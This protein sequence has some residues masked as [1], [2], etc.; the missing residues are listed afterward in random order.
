MSMAVPSALYRNA[1]SGCKHD[2]R[3]ACIGHRSI[4]NVVNEALRRAILR[5]HEDD[6]FGIAAR[7]VDGEKNN[8]RFED[9]RQRVYSATLEGE[10][11]AGSKFAGVR[12][13]AHPERAFAGEHVQVLVGVA[14]EMWRNFAI[15]AKDP[16]ARRGLVGEVGVKEH[17]FG[18]VREGGSDLVQ[19]KT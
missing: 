8:R 15:D 18:G 14:M 7:G 13:I 19:M 11:V 17:R 2:L 9:F 12:G 5:V 3:L 6:V 4:L 10:K 1:A 16:A